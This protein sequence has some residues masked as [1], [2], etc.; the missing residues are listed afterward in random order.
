MRIKTRTGL[1]QA[2]LKNGKMIYNCAKV[3]YLHYL[4]ES[5]LLKKSLQKEFRRNFKIF[6]FT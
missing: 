4:L 2:L 6:T 3:R 1:I 5:K